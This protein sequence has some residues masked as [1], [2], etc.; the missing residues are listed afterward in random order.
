MTLLAGFQ[1]VLA[2]YSGQDDVA[3]GSPVANRTRPE[4][5]NLIGFFANTVIFRT[6]LVGDPTFRD[7]LRRVRRVTLEAYDH[8]ELPFE[9]LVEELQPDRDLS[10]NPLFQVM[11]VLQNTPKP[12]TPVADLSLQPFALEGKTSAF[13][14]TLDLSESE[15]GLWGSLEYNTQLFRPATIERLATHLV[16]LLEPLPG[17]LDQPLSTLPLLSTAIPSSLSRVES[18]S[19]HIG[20]SA[21]S[22][23]PHR[24][25][26][27]S[28]PGGDRPG[29]WRREL[30]YAALNQ[31][32]NQLAHA[33]RKRGVGPECRG[34]LCGTLAGDGDWPASHSESRR[35]LCPP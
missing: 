15:Q 35:R 4:L 30:T 29:L 5:E 17:H 3:V 19:G 18:P 13:D 33:L 32:A 27:C 20:S 8:Q 25:A 1:V 16:T 24:G 28:H 26:S 10:F 14:L 11:L 23:A 21:V 6:S 2:R 12:A 31:R 9:K 7:L 34:H 22:P